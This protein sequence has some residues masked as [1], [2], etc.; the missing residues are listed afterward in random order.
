MDEHRRSTAERATAEVWAGVGGDGPDLDMLAV[1]GDDPV[2]PSAFR[3]GSAA[4][5][6]VAAA[7]LASAVLWR[8]RGGAPGPVT[9]DLRAA[10]RSFRSER[11]LR[12]DGVPCGDLWSPLS[13]DY[14]AGDDRWVRLHANYPHHRAAILKGLGVAD[15]R[16]AVTGAVRDRSAAGVEDAVEAAGGCAALMRSLDD[17]YEHPQRRAL[18]ALP[19]V[20]VAPIDPADGGGPLAAAGP[21]PLSGLRVLDVTHVI[22]GPVCGRVLAAHGADVLH[23]GAAHLPTIPPLVI[24]TGFGKRSCHVD[25]RTAEG[26]DRLRSLV[27]QADIV[28]QSYRPEALAGYGFGP[29]AVATMR[30]GLVVVDL[31]AYG[32]AG[33]WAGRRGFDSLVQMATG[34]ADEGMRRAG[35]DAPRPLPAQALDHA[36]GWLAAFGAVSAVRRRMQIGGSWHVRISLARTGMWLDSL[37]RVDGFDVSQAEQVTDPLATMASAF[38]VLTFVRPAGDIDGATPHWASPPPRPGADPARW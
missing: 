4:A 16:G 7:T 9:V 19:L 1:V 34:M 23:V 2:L 21:R 28:V 30:P 14:R 37:G 26:R 11:F 17:W 18:Q 8:D 33:P 35:A 6:S 10:A 22:A 25:L 36:S 15:D 5:A 13:G 24:D 12:V 31:S 27:S 32:R 29:E 20:E 38:G 3:V